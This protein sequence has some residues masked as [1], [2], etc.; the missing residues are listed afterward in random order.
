MFTLCASRLSAALATLASS[1]LLAGAP[2]LAQNPPAAAPPQD[3][4]SQAAAAVPLPSPPGGYSPGETLREPANPVVAYVDGSSVTLTDIGDAIRA[5][6]S[7][8]RTMPFED[9]YPAMLERLV[10][11]RALVLRAR[12]EHLDTDPVVK[13][14]MREAADRALESELLDRLLDKTATDEVLLA[15]YRKEFD[16]K[17]GPEEVHL[18]VIL[19][20]TEEAARELIKDLEG[21]ADFAT[22]AG[23]ESLDSTRQV[24]GD[25]GFKRQNQ[26]APEVGGAAFVM[27]P[28]QVSANPVQAGQGWFVIKVEARRRAAPPSFAEVRER[29]RQE[30]LQE[31]VARIAHEA[32]AKAVVHEFNINGSPMGGDDA[33]RGDSK[34]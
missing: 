13:R 9:L 32:V 29:L 18:R 8:M 19:V 12:R 28:G 30:V 31:G 17:P 3:N 10:E 4:G 11:Q 25:L 23:R 7:A 1:T 22:L 27:E 24:G 14:H 21:G 15:R 5:L 33:G 16:G 34:R 20:A 26:L 2:V 6:P